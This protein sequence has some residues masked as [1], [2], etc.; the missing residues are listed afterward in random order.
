MRRA[1]NRD[2]GEPAIV[3]ALRAVGATV[4]MLDLSGGPDLL[5][6]FRGVNFLFEIKDPIGPHGGTSRDGQQLSE[7]QLKW[8]R[9]WRGN[10]D[11]VRSPQEALLAIHAITPSE[12]TRQEEI[13]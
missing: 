11:V 6:G 8:H 12:V 5:V 2:K 10:V 7:R 4:G 9:A 13:R 1:P 3:A